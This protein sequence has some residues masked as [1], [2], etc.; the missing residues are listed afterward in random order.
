MGGNAMSWWNA[1]YIIRSRNGMY[2]Q[3]DKG[4]WVENKEEATRYNR[5]ELMHQIEHLEKQ[6][7]ACYTVKAED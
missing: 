2:Y 6:G 3:K 4:C 1:M 7:I 5:A